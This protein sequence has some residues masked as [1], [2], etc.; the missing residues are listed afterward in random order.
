MSANYSYDAQDNI[1]YS[2]ANGTLQS[3]EIIKHLTALL[4]N[5]DIQSSFV[6]IVCIENM[7]DFDFCYSDAEIITGILKDLNEKGLKFFI[8]V[9]NNA[10]RRNMI[11]VM[12]SFFQHIRDE[13][14]PQ[15]FLVE[16]KARAMELANTK[17]QTDGVDLF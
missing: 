12:L 3:A 11:N 10:D 5:I 13:N 4:D 14:I 6:E 2:E 17:I 15:A 9:A 1:V 16:S 7:V 8:F